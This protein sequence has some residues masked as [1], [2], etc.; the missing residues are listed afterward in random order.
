MSPLSNIDSQDQI[1]PF[2]EKAI[3]IPND[4][5][6]CNAA[7]TCLS[8]L[9]FMIDEIDHS[10]ME[11]Q[12]YLGKVLQNLEMLSQ[13]IL[14]SIDSPNV[15]R[16][17]K[18]NLF[19][20]LSCFFWVACDYCASFITKAMNAAIGASNYMIDTFDE[21]S[22][23]WINRLY[24]AVVDMWDAFVVSGT[25]FG[26]LGKDYVPAILEFIQRIVNL[27]YI[28]NQVIKNCVLLLRDLA[29]QYKTS[30]A[31]TVMIVEVS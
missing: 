24:A 9:L 18:P 1:I 23:E 27:Q 29:F 15:S 11:K 17:I 30:V 6:T 12:N 14:A 4:T 31:K 20:C 21:E 2:V 28:S 10:R 26:N 16:D 22:I 7:I 8:D 13:S 25:H 3:Q 5:A 19:T